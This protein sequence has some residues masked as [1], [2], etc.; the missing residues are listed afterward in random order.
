MNRKM[1]FATA[2][3]AALLSLPLVAEVPRSDSAIQSA[4]TQRLEKKQFRN[5]K[6]SVED[7]AVTLEGTVPRL[8]D[9]LDAEKRA[10]K[11]DGVTS[12]KDEIQVTSV[13]DDQL[14][15]Q[16]SRKLAYDRSD[17]G[18]VFNVIQL[19]VNQ[20]VVTLDGEVRTPSDKQSALE[21]VAE[22]PGVQA[23][24]DRLKVAPASFNDD[25]IRLRTL[26]A[27]YRDP[28]LSKYAL[29]PQA[30]IRILVDNGRVGLYGTVDSA[31]DKQV[32]MMRASEV[33]GAF[34]VQNHLT[35]PAEQA[36]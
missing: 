3:A 7:R 9:K 10:R 12:V 35:T 16:L 13:S 27:I 1:K 2:L 26:R 25:D 31:M 17:W 33:F 28:V 29:D 6:A 20:G 5:V 34:Q 4:V 32:A 23:V 21:L 36:R 18:N 11:T 14:R 30:P 8:Q 19:G 24:E 15:N 22:T